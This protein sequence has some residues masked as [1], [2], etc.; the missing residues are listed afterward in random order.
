MQVV[1]GGIKLSFFNCINSVPSR[2]INLMRPFVLPYSQSFTWIVT[3]LFPAIYC[4]WVR[5]KDSPCGINLEVAYATVLLCC[6][7]YFIYFIKLGMSNST[8]M[9][10]IHVM[11]LGRNSLRGNALRRLWVL[12]KQHLNPWISQW[13][14]NTLTHGTLPCPWVGLHKGSL[15]KWHLL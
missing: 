8:T 7:L 12:P 2:Y 1:T 5:P 13:Y 9:S 15:E 11:H 4:S 10:A 14:W 3:I 6:L